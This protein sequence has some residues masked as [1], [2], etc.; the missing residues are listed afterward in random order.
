MLFLFLS[1]CRQLLLTLALGFGLAALFLLLGNALLLRLD[2]FAL[3]S[4]QNLDLW[5]FQNL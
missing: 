5:I 3:Q 1:Y 4:S 2:L